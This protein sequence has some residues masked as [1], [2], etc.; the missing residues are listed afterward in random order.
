MR[1]DNVR[2]VAARPVPKRP[3]GT[4]VH[5]DFE[6]VPQG[7]G[8]FVKGDAGGATDPRTHIAQ[9]HAPYTQR[10]WNGKAIDDVID[11][12]NSLK[13]RG[14]NTG[15]IYRTVPHTVRFTPGRRYRV[16]F[17]YENEKAGQYA[18]ITAVDGPAPRETDRKD[19]PVATEPTT[20]AYEF[21]A[22]AD[23]EAWVGL[24]KTGDDG[25]AEFVLDAFEVTSVTE[26]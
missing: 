26:D 21:T 4:L 10:G 6:H 7:W 14:E 15:L 16:S 11:G 12:G 2:V 23:G 5:E 22:P 20:L 13:S 8:P 3:R 25:E 18:W 9:R 19:L 1:F 17:R 24:R